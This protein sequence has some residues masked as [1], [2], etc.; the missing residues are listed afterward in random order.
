M[1]IFDSPA[2]RTRKDLSVMISGIRKDLCGCISELSIELYSSA[3]FS[4]LLEVYCALGA[5]QYYIDHIE[6]GFAIDSKISQTVVYTW[7][8]PFDTS[9]IVD[10]AISAG[11]AVYSR[12][13]DQ[14][15]IVPDILVECANKLISISFSDTFM[16][17]LAIDNQN[18]AIIAMDISNGIIAACDIADVYVWHDINKIDVFLEIGTLISG[19][20]S[21]YLDDIKNGICVDVAIK[22]IARMVA[23]VGTYYTGEPMSSIWEKTLLDLYYI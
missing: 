7:A 13:S 9:V 19:T 11:Q 22:H 4:A 8:A 14:A 15:A 6:D 12:L 23:M 18:I 10:E 17:D 20:I 16:I 1:K 3:E 2:G 5:A 21:S